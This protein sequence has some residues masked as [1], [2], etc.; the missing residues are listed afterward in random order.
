MYI[1]DLDKKQKRDELLIEII[2]EEM[3]NNF[4]RTGNDSRNISSQE[5]FQN[6]V[7]GKLLGGQWK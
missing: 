7:N 3:Y 6:K 2:A 5:H 4:S 1:G